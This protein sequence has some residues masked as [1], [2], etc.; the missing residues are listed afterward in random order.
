MNDIVARFE[1]ACRECG[2]KLTLQRLEIFREL[3]VA[4]DHPSADTVYARLRDRFPALSRDTVF[5]TLATLAAHGL[6]SKVETQDSVARY[7]VVRQKHHHF[8]CRQCGTIVDFL[9][10]EMEA[11]LLPTEATACG[12]VENTS[13]IAHGICLSCLASRRQG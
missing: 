2:L 10:P 7:E 9:W 3:L 5:R 1:T 8:I 13:V 11:M 12:C 4:T 6:I